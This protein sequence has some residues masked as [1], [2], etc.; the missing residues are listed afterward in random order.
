ML[1]E[2]SNFP[3]PLD[4]EPTHE[5]VEELLRVLSDPNIAISVDEIEAIVS[6]QDES[7]P[8]DPYVE[9]SPKCVHDLGLIDEVINC[10]KDLT[11]KL[12]N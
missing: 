10:V 9:S 7:R 12:A 5:A 11:R 4:K 1:M 3:N 8:F 6:G 2:D